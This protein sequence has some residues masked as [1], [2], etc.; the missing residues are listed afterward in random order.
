MQWNRKGTVVS[1]R[2]GDGRVRARGRARRVGTALAAAGGLSLLSGCILFNEFKADG[3]LIEDDCFSL[4][5]ASFCVDFDSGTLDGTGLHAGI[6]NSPHCKR[7]KKIKVS[8]WVD[9]NDNGTEDEGEAIDSTE[10]EV[11]EEEG[12]NELAMGDVSLGLNAGS[13]EVGDVHLRIE[14][15][16]VGSE[17]TNE[18]GKTI[19]KC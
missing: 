9:K 17:T 15:T 16:R 5:A 7:I 11:A 4:F 19:S 14:V 3:F 1:A 12:S 8:G 6:S 10:H 13:E 18:Y 2:D